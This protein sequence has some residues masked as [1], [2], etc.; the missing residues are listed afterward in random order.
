MAAHVGD[1]DV[2]WKVRVLL[3]AFTRRISSGGGRGSI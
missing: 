2:H 3:V 1:T